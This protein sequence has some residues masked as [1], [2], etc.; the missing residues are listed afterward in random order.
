VGGITHGRERER[1]LKERG[2][3]GG[4]GGGGGCSH[5]T[6]LFP[7]GGEKEGGRKRWRAGGITSTA[8]GLSRGGGSFLMDGTSVSSSILSVGPG[9]AV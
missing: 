6:V 9:G 4:G 1:H 8:S 5:Y 3:G 7:G 2:G